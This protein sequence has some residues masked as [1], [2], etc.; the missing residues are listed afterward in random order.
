MSTKFANVSL[1]LAD[2]RNQPQA[3]HEGETILAPITQREFDYVF[4]D[5]AVSEDTKIDLITGKIRSFSDCPADLI[6]SL[7]RYT[8]ENVEVF[9]GEYRSAEVIDWSGIEEVKPRV[10]PATTEDGKPVL[11]KDGSQVMKIDPDSPMVADWSYTVSRK[12]GKRNFKN[13][14]HPNNRKL[15][16]D[17]SKA[18]SYTFSAHK[19]AMNGETF[20]FDSMGMGASCNHRTTAMQ[21]AVLG[22]WDGSVPLIVVVGIPALF[23]NTIDT[24]RSR[25]AIDTQFRDPTVL[26]IDTLR[27]IDGKEHSPSKVAEIKQ[28]LARMLASVETV[29]YHR[30]SGA[31]VNAS[32]SSK[33]LDTTAKNAVFY[34]IK[35]GFSNLEQLVQDVHNA[36]IGR[37]GVSTWGKIIAPHYVAAGLSLYF[38]AQQ[39]PEECLDPSTL[40]VGTVEIPIEQCRTFLAQLETASTAPTEFGKLWGAVA[41]AKKLDNREKMGAVLNLIS[42]HFDGETVARPKSESNPIPHASNWLAKGEK[43]TKDNP[44]RYPHFGGPDTPKGLRTE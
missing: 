11:A 24:G 37:G 15:R 27:N 14:F 5:G 38:A 28:K 30:L 36:D 4:T 23:V 29:L 3:V 6:Q 2:C 26:P 17:A 42:L 33:G 22:G 32:M 40:D 43:A 25:T 12:E 1:A 31:D 9:V 7:N 10:I 39:F 18:L 8:L 35:G 21:M 41:D 19:W 16:E 13:R 44:A 34:R 20:I